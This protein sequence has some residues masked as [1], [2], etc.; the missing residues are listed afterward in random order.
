MAGNPGIFSEI[1][2]KPA[3][4]TDRLRHLFNTGKDQLAVWWENQREK[5]PHHQLRKLKK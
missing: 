3:E 4:V 5:Y 2:V 1:E